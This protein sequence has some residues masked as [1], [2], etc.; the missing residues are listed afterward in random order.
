MIPFAIVRGV[1]PR[2]KIGRS[3]PDVERKRLAY[4]VIDPHF[5]PE[6]IGPAQSLKYRPPHIEG[7]CGA[8]IVRAIGVPRSRNYRARFPDNVIRQTVLA[9]EPTIASNLGEIDYVA[10]VATRA[11]PPLEPMA[12]DDREVDLADKILAQIGLAPA[13]LPKPLVVPIVL[14]HLRGWEAKEEASKEVAAVKAFVKFPCVVHPI[15]RVIT[16]HVH[17]IVDGVGT[18]GGLL[19]KVSSTRRKR[20]SLCR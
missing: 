20:S 9:I 11:D 13:S 7:R 12:L 16:Y 19:A 4:V 5:R 10:A 17:P 14:G 2:G 8:L 18:S 1:K 15:T 3:Q 6:P